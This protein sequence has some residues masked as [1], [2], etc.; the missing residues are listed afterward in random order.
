MYL[1]RSISRFILLF[2]DRISSIIVVL[3]TGF[4]TATNGEETD[5][6]SGPLLAVMAPVPC[7]SEKRILSIFGFFPFRL[8]IEKLDVVDLPSAASSDVM[9]PMP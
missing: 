7:G 3:E 1:R 8:V 2:L 4:D 9:A 5:L 6:L